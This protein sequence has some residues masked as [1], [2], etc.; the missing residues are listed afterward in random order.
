MFIDTNKISEKGL[1]VSNSFSLDEDMLIEENAFFLDDLKYHV[2]FKQ[3]VDRIEAKGNIKT[4]ISLGCVK[5]LDD[6][7]LNI[8]L[9]FDIILFP[10]NLVNS[11]SHSIGSDEM[12]YIF[13]DDNRID[14]IKIL[15][16]QIN[17]FIPYNPICKPNCKGICPN[18]GT[19]LNYAKCKCENSSNELNFLFNKIKR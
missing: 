10:T 3:D 5:C 14:L 1:I 11:E 8:D 9:N 19:N 15:L 4:M 12:E 6:F 13:Y 16:E 2:L 17:L 18:C 7:E